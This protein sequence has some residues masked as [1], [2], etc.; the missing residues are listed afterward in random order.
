MEGASRLGRIGGLALAAA[1]IGFFV[2]GALHPHGSPGQDFRA[3][4]VSMLESPMWPA[5]HWSALASGLLAA[6]AVWLLVDA[7]WTGGSTV[8][9]A[10]ARLTILASVFMAV[11][12]SVEIASRGAA[13]AYAA[14]ESA[15]LVDLI[16]PMQAVGWP[17][18]ALGFILLAVGVPDSAPR[19][20]VAVGVVGAAAIGLAGIL[21]QGLHIVQL[22]PLF[23]GGNLL[24]VW[25]VWAGL[26]AG[27]GRSEAVPRTRPAV[28]RAGAGAAS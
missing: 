27:R 24:S 14:G 18:L 10:G 17:A 6:W 13:A 8:A 19:G 2:A 7:G 16:D 28:E 23:M 4:I 9:R 15:P 1:G 12:F 5:A 20:V 22:G 21:V 26:R 11:Q 3:G 25:M